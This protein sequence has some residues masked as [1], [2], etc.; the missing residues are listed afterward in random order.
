MTIR[1]PAKS[2]VRIIV[3][4]RTVCKGAAQIGVEA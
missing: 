1:A 2:T 4:I 3:P